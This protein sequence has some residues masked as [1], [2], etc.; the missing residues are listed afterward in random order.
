[1]GTVAKRAQLEELPPIPWEEL[2]QRGVWGPIARPLT[3]PFAA[4]APWSIGSLIL[5]VGLP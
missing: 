5:A 3:S 4:D 2:L 1:M